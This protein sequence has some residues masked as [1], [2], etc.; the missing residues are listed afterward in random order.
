MPSSASKK[1]KEPIS[2]R[3]LEQR[4]LSY[5]HSMAGS[6]THAI[7]APVS[8]TQR[9]RLQTSRMEQSACNVSQKLG[10]SS[11]TPPKIEVDTEAI[12]R[13]ILEAIGASK[14]EIVGLIDYLASECNL[15]RHDLE[16]IRGRLNTAEDRIPEVQDVSHTQGSQLA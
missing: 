5:Q 13:P 16:K 6:S 3:Q 8:G 12:T 4:Q 15:I 2:Q 1:L 9:A 7:L 10:I 14:S 11:P